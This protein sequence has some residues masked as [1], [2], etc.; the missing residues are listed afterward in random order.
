MK[1]PFTGHGVFSILGREIAEIND[2]STNSLIILRT[3]ELRASSF[4]KMDLNGYVADFK[5]GK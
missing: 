2:S 5:N 1:E 4:N 3:N